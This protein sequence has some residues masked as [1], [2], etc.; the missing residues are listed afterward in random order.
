[1]VAGASA[2]DL[3]QGSSAG[4]W[5]KGKNRQQNTKLSDDTGRRLCYQTIMRF[6]LF[7]ARAVVLAA[8]LLAAMLPVFLATAGQ[9][10]TDVQHAQVMAVV[11][12]VMPMQDTTQD[13]AAQD[14]ADVQMMQCQDHCLPAAS[15]LPAQDRTVEPGVA[16]SDFVAAAESLAA[17]LVVPPPGPPPKVALI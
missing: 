11:G 6:G 2:N 15:G 5:R 8:Y 10:Q 7:R 16:T 13:S 12:H 17:S 1:M 14:S 9:A 3:G 4:S